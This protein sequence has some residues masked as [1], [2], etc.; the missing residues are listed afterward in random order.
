MLITLSSLTD[1]PVICDHKTIG[2]VWRV[3]FDLTNGQVLGILLNHD[4][5][6]YADAITALTND[7]AGV[8]ACEPVR[9]GSLVARAAAAPIHILGARVVA[10][11]GTALG[12]VSDASIVFPVLQL[13]SI[14]VGSEDGERLIARTHIISMTD[15]RIV[16]RSDLAKKV[17][18]WN[19]AAVRP[20][21]TTN[22]P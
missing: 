9:A 21:L 1:S 2:R 15:D 13:H 10:E 14:V 8:R 18:D 22:R 11:D 16:V 19:G 20:A 4:T 6:V 12:T 17:F 3:A 7:G 5:V